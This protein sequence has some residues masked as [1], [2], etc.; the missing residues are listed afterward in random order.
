MEP[1]VRRNFTFPFD[2]LQSFDPTSYITLEDKKL[3]VMHDVRTG[4]YNFS[5]DVSDNWNRFVLHFTPAAEITTVN[6]ICD[7]QGAINIA[8]PGSANWTYT[9]ENSNAVV[10]S[11]GT[12]NSNSPATIAAP[13]GTYTLTLV[14]ANSYTVVK[15]IIVNGSQPIVASFTPSATNAETIDDIIFTATTPNAT[16]YNWDFGDGT[17]ASTATAIHIYPVAGTYTVTLTVT[18]A[19]GCSSTI[20][21]TVTITEH[22]V[23]GLNNVVNNTG[24]RIWSN[25]NTVFVDFSRSLNVKA[26][27]QVYNMLGQLLSEES[28]SR[29]AVYTKPINNLEASYVIVRVKNDKEVKVK[30]VFIGNK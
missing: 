11:N 17:T 9:L 25:V 1:G 27:V 30:K 26:T 21:Q 20:T 8:Q 28:F 29:S 2:G 22:V 23:S 3:A 12:L 18:N 7:V 14:D 10:V 5:S 24:I 16:V 13:A 4:N 19:D 15:S 6:Q